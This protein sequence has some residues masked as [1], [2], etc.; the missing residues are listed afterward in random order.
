MIH[1][2]SV[3]SFW[4][5]DNFFLV[6]VRSSTRRGSSGVYK[7]IYGTEGTFNPW[8]NIELS[9]NTGTCINLM[10]GWCF[11]IVFIPGDAALHA[12]HHG[13]YQNT[14]TIFSSSPA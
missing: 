9:S 3:S 2:H 4:N 8:C 12:L 11:A 5:P 6:I 13:E 1:L 7:C 10:F 14:A